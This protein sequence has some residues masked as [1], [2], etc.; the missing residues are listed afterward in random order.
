M[1]NVSQHSHA[2]SD[3]TPFPLMAIVQTAQDMLV[4]PRKYVSTTTTATSSSPSPPSIAASASVLTSMVAPSPFASSSSYFHTLPVTIEPLRASKVSLPDGSTTGVDMLSVLPASWRSIYESSSSGLLKPPLV[5][6]AHL[7]SLD[8]HR[9]KVYGSQRE[10]VS[11]IGR[12]LS[13][14]MIDIAEP[15]DVKCVNGLF[16]ITKDQ[17]STR[18][19]V[20]GRYANA[21]FVDPPT[22]RLPTPASFISLSLPHGQTLYKA[23]QDISNFYHNI[24]L[25]RWL[26][27]YFALPPV[28]VSQLPIETVRQSAK[29]SALPSDALVH[30]VL[31][32]LAMGFSHAVAIAQSIHEHVLYNTNTLSPS[33][34]ILNLSHP[35][36][37]PTPVHALY[38][39]DNNMLGTCPDRLKDTY[40]RCLVAYADAGF[41][42]KV[43][44]CVTPTVEP[45]TMI[46][47]SVSSNGI[48]SLP[49]DRMREL[50][51]VTVHAIVSGRCTGLRLASIVGSW[52]WC[53]LLRRFSLCIFKSVY[54]FAA[55]AKG[56]EY[57]LWPS[58]IRELS[59]IIAIAPLL[60][61]NMG[62]RFFPKIVATDASTTGA[63]MSATNLDDGTFHALFPASGLHVHDSSS[64]PPPAAC[65]SAY[66]CDA[67]MR[68]SQPH[69]VA[70]SPSRTAAAATR[71]AYDRITATRW[72]DIVAYKWRHA[73][74]INML[75]L[76]VVNMAMKWIASH[77]ASLGTRAFL[78]IDNAASY[79]ALRKGRSTKM[80]PIMKKIAALALAA[81][82]SLS[83]VWV[84]SL[85]NPADKASRRFESTADEG[86]KPTK[87]QHRRPP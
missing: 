87:H 75:E 30:P 18:L 39:D 2:A 63:G 47:V 3:V 65:S 74:H 54:R 32:R 76:T 19:I 23:K 58:V 21:L 35:T 37:S 24:I 51:S 38:V 64:S 85:V 60:R 52:T 73:D 22:V 82:L 41:P 42:V 7:R 29:L 53:M 78:C 46:G 26:Q 17:T 36:V 40:E 77:P 71:C 13:I 57:T 4:D 10:Y 69:L 70:L 68:L 6:A 81:G 20:D 62:S 50:L 1:P 16:T 84:P 67:V 34:N 31:L 45:V 11:L 48:V 28:R 5:G 12:L 44:K 72:Y 66:T 83:L 33:M 15:N 14:D 27:V 80:L 55:C 8:L 43:S 49:V 59:S 9:P 25:P 79:Y 86:R 56:K 61:S